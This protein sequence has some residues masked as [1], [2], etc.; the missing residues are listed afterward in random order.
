LDVVRRLVAV[1]GVCVLAACGGGSK[2]SSTASVTVPVSTTTSTSVVSVSTTTTS[3]STTTT[4]RSATSTTAPTPTTTTTTT[5]PPKAVSLTNANNGNH[6]ALN[7]GDAVVISLSA[8]PST[9]YSWVVSHSP[10]S[11]VVKVVSTAFQPDPCP[12][13]QV[14]CGGH[15]V[16]RL[17]AVAA[18]STSIGMTNMRIGSPAA[19]TFSASFSVF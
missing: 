13:G 10:A 14:G 4:T 3:S 17:Q 12:P 2:N 5:V 6:V 11:A 18:G 15:Q 8:N 19:A 16:I 1:F 9:G 7:P